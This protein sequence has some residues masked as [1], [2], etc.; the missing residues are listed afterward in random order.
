[1]S[2]ITTPEPAAAA[3]VE[4][5]VD[6]PDRASGAFAVEA[7]TVV[8]ACAAAAC[9]VV[10]ASAAGTGAAW[11]IA[12][13]VLGWSAAAVA[14]AVRRPR[15]PLPIV[16]V[17]IPV[18]GGIAVLL[19][20]RAATSDAAADARVVAIAAT[21]GAM[22]H[23]AVSLPAGSLRDRR[24]V[25]VV[26]A[27]L[28]CGAV[29]IWSLDAAPSISRAPLVFGGVVL[30]A[31]A[32]PLV[33]ARGRQSSS[34]E[35][36]ELLWAWW[37]ALVM[38]TVVVVAIAM[39]ELTGWPD[40]IGLVTVVASMFLPLALVLS[41]VGRLARI[42]P[43]LVVDTI[44]ASGLVLA[45][46]AMFVLV[47]VGFDG[48]PT[49][50]QRTTIGLSMVA[51]AVIA[52]LALPVRRRLESF[53]NQQVYGER[54]SPGAALDTF[55]SR[56]SRAVPMDELL[57]Q[58]AETLRKT[59]EVRRAE[60]WTGSDGVFDLAVSV[61]ARRADRIS[62]GRDECTVAARTPIAGTAWLAVWVPALA[63]GRESAM[64]RVATVAHLGDLLGFL[65]VERDVD[66]TAFDDEQD[67][68]LTDIARQ[69]GLA[70]HNVRLDT[71]LQASLDE[72]KV[73]NAELVASRARIVATA[74]RS[75]REIER[76]LHDGAQQHLV[77]MAVKLGLTQ[78]LLDSD[79]EKSAAMLGE[80]RDD[81]QAT[82]TE[83]RELAHGIYPPLLRSRGLQ[84]ALVA[85]ANRATISTTVHAEGVPRFDSEVEAAVYFCCLEA[86]QNAGKHAGD[87]AQATVTV[88]HADGELLFEIRDDGKGFDAAAVAGGHGFV[89]MAD[90]L[91]AI[92]GALTVTS[93]PGAGTQITGRLP[94]R[95]S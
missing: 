13:V 62:L 36:A 48:R 40:H 70:L 69:L 37:G 28:V 60:V 67:R 78:Q 86:M 82:L 22:F 8:L 59:M 47:V 35:R 44:V 3:K 17:V 80:L 16:A 63:D 87:G 73:R 15:R 57:L 91:G 49:G 6:L 5:P 31:I 68:V 41:T 52:V 32:A 26:A 10:G 45:A 2:A 33:L 39:S 54:Q 46:T 34:S 29:A 30:A 51:T 76:N 42:V 12:A 1:V 64:L 65:V 23:L 93:T 43:R 18:L 25:A 7:V 88:E 24:W 92:G 71:A 55:G 19:T 84:E 58:L 11:V 9:A 27:Y 14:L 95:I 77:A 56:M 20:D 21:G 83:L 53:A 66:A 94:V 61:P 75:R 89:N 4:R 72:L 79:P 74:D 50:E 90:R 81:V 38:A 85:A